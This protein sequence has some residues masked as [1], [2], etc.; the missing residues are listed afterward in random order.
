FDHASYRAAGQQPE[1]MGAVHAAWAD[2]GVR[3]E[4]FWLGYATGTA[5]GWHPGSPAPEESMSAFYRLFYGP[6]AVNVGRVYQLL[7]R[8]AQFWADSWERGP[9]AARKPIFGWSDGIYSPPRPPSDQMLTLP[10]VPHEHSVNV[11]S[12]RGS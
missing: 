10:P 2:A 12:T 7:G 1:L 4:T 6:S 11:S 3:P 9:S 8:Q 5:A